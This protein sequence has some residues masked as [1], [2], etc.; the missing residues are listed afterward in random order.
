MAYSE[1]IYS[2]IFIFAANLVFTHFKN[3][4]EGEDQIKALHFT[5]DWI[6]IQSNSS[7]LDI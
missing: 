5:Q 2:Y 6:D 7:I 3:K 4:T 1:A